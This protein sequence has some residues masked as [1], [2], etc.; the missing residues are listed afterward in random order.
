MPPSRPP[1]IPRR[2]LGTKGIWHDPEP[3][4]LPPEAFSDGL[5]VFFDGNSCRRAPVFRFLTD[6]PGTSPFG[7]ACRKSPAGFDTLFILGFLGDIR[8]LISGV[9]TDVTPTSGWASTGSTDQWTSTFLGDVTYVNRPTHVPAGFGSTSTDFEVM[10]SWDSTWRC[11]ALRAYKDALIALNVTKGAVAYPQMVKTS[12][13]TLAGLFPGSW[14]ETDPATNATEN[15]LGDLTTPIVDGAVLGDSFLIYSKDQVWSMSAVNT[16]DVY[17]YRKVLTDTGAIAPNCIIECDGKHYVF[18]PGDIYRH[19][20]S[21]LDKE[22]IVEGRNRRYIFDEIDLAKSGRCF[23]QHYPNHRMILFAYPTISGR[24][25]HEAVNGCNKAF[26]Y[27]YADDTHSFIALPDVT[28]ATI[29]NLDVV[30][31]WSTTTDTWDSAG[32]TWASAGGTYRSS[33]LFCSSAENDTNIGDRLMGYD[34][35]NDGPLALPYDTTANEPAF[36]ERTGLDYDDVGAPLRGGKTILGIM[37]QIT[38]PTPSNLRFELGSALVPGVDTTWE[39]VQ[40]FVPGTDYKV[41]ARMSGRYL[42]I[43]VR[44]GPV[45]GVP[46]PIDAGDWKWTGYDIEVSNGGGR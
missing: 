24:T 25:S 30:P 29:T 44:S 38:M 11:G 34:F 32:G 20:G 14:D 28:G 42:S 6:D 4:D 18:G 7:M 17:A 12:D 45:E 8:S 3:W 27:D 37:P 36:I 33:L 10:P 1:P 2:G 41:D 31:L 39:V 46:P 19:G 21:G 23:V 16:R 22:S 9:N 13:K 35:K 5:N 26:V 43:R 40:G 15:I